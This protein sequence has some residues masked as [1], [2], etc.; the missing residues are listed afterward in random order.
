MLIIDLSLLLYY[1]LFIKIVYIYFL[2]KL[3]G[4]IVDLEE[5]LL[6][7]EG[8]IP[9]NVLR[10]NNTFILIANIIITSIISIHLK[11][12]IIFEQNNNKFVIAVMQTKST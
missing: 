12:F 1:Y 10:I 11:Y 6:A 5:I 3:V 7:D 4:Q 2:L 8:P 9:V